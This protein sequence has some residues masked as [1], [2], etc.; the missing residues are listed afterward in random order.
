M[1]L[2]GD[3]LTAVKAVRCWTDRTDSGLDGAT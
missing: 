3:R 2:N 1:T